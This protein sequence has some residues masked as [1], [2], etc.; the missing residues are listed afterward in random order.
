MKKLLLLA[1]MLWLAACGNGADESGAENPEEQ[2]EETTES[3]EGET[4][5]E[6]EES[7]MTAS[8]LLDESSSA[9]GDTVSYEARQTSTI[10]SG[11]SQY[12][13]R[14][15][16]TRSEAD[17]IKVEVDDGEEIK[18]HY[19]VEG[20]HFIYQ[21]N[22]TEAQ[23][24]P[25]EIGGSEYGALIS[26]LEPYREGTVTEV[27]SGYELRYTMDGKEGAEPFLDDGMAE[28]LDDV[29]TFSGQ[30]TL[31]FNDE[32]QYTEAK[33]TLTVGSG[34]EEVNIISN[35]TMDR[36]GEVDRIEKPKNM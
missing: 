29:D 22:N 10:S 9:W 36:I 24:A 32:F 6:E 31:Q 3:H 21:G 14:T 28:L 33:F 15:I 20:E 2:N 5:S 35:I 12:V 30:V 16:T 8:E 34:E 18:T 23:D 25:R 11:E 19:I 27:E 17:E 7:S 1:V 26:G 4:Q 13:F